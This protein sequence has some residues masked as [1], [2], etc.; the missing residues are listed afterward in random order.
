MKN[1][2]LFLF[3]VVLVSCKN[4]IKL[5][6]D[7]LVKDKK[8]KEWIFENKE[9]YFISGVILSNDK[10]SI[11]I[12]NKIY[13]FNS[14]AYL[15][16]KSIDG[17]IIDILILNEDKYKNQYMSIKKEK[18]IGRDL[19]LYKCSSCHGISPFVR[20]LGTNTLSSKF[21]KQTLNYKSHYSVSKS[22]FD[23]LSISEL[24]A[25]KVY[26]TTPLGQ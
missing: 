4:F 5:E 15:V 18:L 14:S 21:I 9:D 12:N 16:E 7:T 19:F 25:I 17:Q 3:I 26:L 23:E 10:D 13:Y 2:I 22:T 24:E 11:D 6:K 1:I 20:D 8:I